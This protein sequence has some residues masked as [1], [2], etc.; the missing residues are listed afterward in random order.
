[1]AGNPGNGFIS[2]KTVIRQTRHN[3]LRLLLLLLLL[4][5]FYE[6]QAGAGTTKLLLFSFDVYISQHNFAYQ[7]LPKEEFLTAKL[8][9]YCH[10]SG[11]SK[12]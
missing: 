4:L 8:I 6:V 1:M 12:S 2:Y 3:Q 7:L 5:L 9:T 10:I 11:V